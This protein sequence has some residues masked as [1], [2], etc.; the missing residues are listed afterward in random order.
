MMQQFEIVHMMHTVLRYRVK[1]GKSLPEDQ[2]GVQA[3]MRVDGKNAFD[4]AT[5]Q[6]IVSKRNPFGRR[7]KQST[8][9]KF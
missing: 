3:A 4:K 8:A 6:S 9:K 5:K 1:H 2:L 7:N